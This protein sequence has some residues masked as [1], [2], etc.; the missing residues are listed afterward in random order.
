[1]TK[2]MKFVK[3]TKQ[4]LLITISI[5]LVAS[6][7][8]WGAV[9]IFKA[10]PPIE[11]IE[12]G[13]KLIA[14]AIEAEAGLYSPGEFALA[15]QYWQE[16]MAE[17]KLSNERSP[18]VR[19]FR[20]ASLMADMAIEHA[21]IALNYARERKNELQGKARNE[22]AAIKEVLIAIDYISGKFPLNHNIEK[23]LTQ[24]SITHNEAEMAFLR[25]DLII[26]M[27][28]IESIKTKV[29]ELEENTNNILE[30]Y[31]SSYSQ[32]V[33]LNEEMKEWSKKHNS[34]SIVVD[35]FSR[36]CTVYKSGKKYRDFNVELGINWLG[37]KTQSGDRATPEGKY[38]VSG[39]RSGNRTLY[40]K[41]LEINYPNE[42]DKQ[43]FELEKRSGN[44]SGN[45][46]IGGSIAIH[47]DGGRGIDWTEGCVA[48]EN[49]DM[50]ILF[51]LCP[52]GTPV[53]IVGSLVPLDKIYEDL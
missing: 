49:R 35:K 10:N 7:C 2:R 25:N 37:D 17:W 24:I 3:Y 36:K 53:A 28:K 34:V 42:D 27:D 29:F 26:A 8:L 23:E 1:M 5:F 19:N 13:R 14:K 38:K 18:V 21:E 11:K 51:S 50:D 52:V 4:T 30:N 20:K 9:H 6:G 32:W 31:F 15:E 44:I 43:R 48:L 12:I 47:G 41:S 39:K 46:R 16:A 40:H 45:A 22:L 33:L